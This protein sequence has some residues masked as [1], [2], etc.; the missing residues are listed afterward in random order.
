[1][2]LNYMFIL[3]QIY[4]LSDVH[5]LKIRASIIH[6]VIQIYKYNIWNVWNMDEAYSTHFTTIW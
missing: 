1:M 2:N 3:N 4:H 5:L 6:M